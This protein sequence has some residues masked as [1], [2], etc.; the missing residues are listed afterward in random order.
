MGVDR[1][2]ERCEV[3]AMFSTTAKPIMRSAAWRISM[4]A[5]LAF[6][7]GTMVVFIFLHQFV[8]GDIQRRTDAWLAGEAG[9]LSDV[10]ARTPKGVL[11]RRVVEEVAELAS[12]EVPHKRADN[13]GLNDS[14]FFLQTG[15]DG[16]VGL[17][18]GAGDVNAHLAAVRNRKIVPDTPTSLHITGF[19]APFRV[20]CV[21]MNNGS[22]VY[23]GLSERDQLRVLG[24]LRLRFVLLW[25]LIVLIGSAIVFYSTRRVLRHIRTITEAASR[26]GEADLS[27]RVPTTGRN[28]EVSQLAI[29]LNRMLDRI[30]RS[31]HQL[32]TITG[33]LAH[34]LRSPLTAVRAKLEMSLTAGARDEESESIVSAIE[35]MDRL[36]EF[37]DKSLDVAEAK[38]NALR[39]NRVA[40]DLDDL[41]RVMIDLYEPSMSEK[42]LRVNLCSAGWLEVSADAALLHRMIANLFDNELKHL[43]ASCTVTISLSAS[44]DS[45]L[46]VVEDDGPGFESEVLSQIFER[47]VKGRNSTGHGLGLAFVEAVVRVHGGT[48]KASNGSEGGARL[49]ITLPLAVHSVSPLSPAL[50]HA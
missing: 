35:D 50:A 1:S 21:R 24:K 45:A 16:S 43:R 9:V 41:L 27:S 7:C 23:L 15:A 10:A 18:V 11:Y 40:V 8:A 37:L 5:T 30:E 47:R 6:A 25:L 33:S 28:D 39:L 3:W 12:R 4:W 44:Q 26:I 19:D 38:A 48:I 32:H 34:D 29:T 17:W 46:L 22:Q 2:F 42:G 20:V 13:G 49:T 14:V 31:V 36:T